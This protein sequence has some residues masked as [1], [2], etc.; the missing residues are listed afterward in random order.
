M[1]KVARILKWIVWGLL[2]LFILGMIAWTIANA[3]A[4][5]RFDDAVRE[6]EQ[7]GYPIDVPAIVPP[8]L[9]PAENAAPYYASAFALAARPQSNEV[10]ILLRSTEAR[11]VAALTAE[12]KVRLREW[13]AGNA[14]AVD[15]L[16]RARKR[17]GCR[18]PRDY[19]LGLALPLP[20]LQWIA[21]LAFELSLRAQLEV[22]DGKVEDARA[23]VRDIFKLSDSVRDEPL[24]VSQMVRGTA[25]SFAFQ[26]IDRCVKAGSRPEELREWIRLLPSA[27]WYSGS[28]SKCLR[29]ELAM[30]TDLLSRSTDD[31]EKQLEL[32]RGA[33]NPLLVWL[34]QPVVRSD[35]TT[36]LRLLSRLIDAGGKPFPEARREC[37]AVM[38]EMHE[39]K[40]WL[41]PVTRCLLPSVPS[42]LE[43][44]ATVNARRVVLRAGLEAELKRADS[45]KYPDA[46]DGV[47]PFTGDPLGYD[48]TAGKITSVGRRTRPQ[49]IEWTLR[50]AGK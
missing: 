5:V 35:G 8:D 44:E 26:A 11:G 6:L 39:M 20:E 19:R 43:W 50:E 36:Y 47:D 14:E 27:G 22:E 48:R 4:N 31:Y 21:S 1:S 23:T 37:D 30:A 40:G 15:M 13:L 49:P 2:V 18:Y 32:M 3:V 9:P 41:H 28:I 45:G 24:L 25:A 16:V 29:G 34:A 33:P 38:A 10:S 7:A 46:V 42:C 17:P 12:E